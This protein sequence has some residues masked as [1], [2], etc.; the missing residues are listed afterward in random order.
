MR[1]PSHCLVLLLKLHTFEDLVGQVLVALEVENDHLAILSSLG[2][3][4][5]KLLLS[6]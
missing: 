2:H 4:G 6:R 1:H 5:L 3:L